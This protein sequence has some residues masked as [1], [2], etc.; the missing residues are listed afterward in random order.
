MKLWPFYSADDL[1]GMYPAGRADHRARRLARIWAVVFALGLFPR[2]W[3]TLEVPGRKAGRLT[4]FPL[5][6]AEA[7]GCWYLVPMLG[8]QSNWVQNARA[9]GGL[10]TI[11]RGRAVAVRLAEV[12]VS[13][14]APILKRYLSQVPGARP[15]IP[16]SKDAAIPEFEAIASRYPV[17]RVER[18]PAGRAARPAPA[19]PLRLPVPAEE[20]V[21]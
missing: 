17:F 15:H 13:E 18:H 7:D 12:P 3:V 8:E 9:A 4:R 11:R 16:V 20:D 2:R 21:V 5:G 1:R 6:M 14:R 10:V 19:V